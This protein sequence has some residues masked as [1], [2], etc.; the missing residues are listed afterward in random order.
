MSR[1]FKFLGRL[2]AKLAGIPDV[3]TKWRQVIPVSK[4]IACVAEAETFSCLSGVQKRRYAAKRIA[5]W[6]KFKGYLIPESVLNFMIEEAFQLWLKQTGN[7]PP[8]PT[9]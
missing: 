8:A 6:A 3:I 1:F 7:Q 2:I 4:V 9:R 5:E